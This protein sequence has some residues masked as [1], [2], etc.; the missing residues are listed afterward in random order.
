M[1]TATTI[2]LRSWISCLKTGFE[3]CD[4]QRSRNNMLYEQIDK[5]H[6]RGAMDQ[7]TVFALLHHF[8]L[9]E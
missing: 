8:D 1:A 4:S 2:S 5:A 6:R 3:R 7:K 9:V